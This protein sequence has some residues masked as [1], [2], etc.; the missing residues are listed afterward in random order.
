MASDHRLLR[1]LYRQR[2][3][4]PVLP[5]QPR[6][7]E[8]G[9]VPRPGEGLQRPTADLRPALRVRTRSGQRGVGLCR[10]PQ[11]TTPL[12][13][14]N[15]TIKQPPI[16][17]SI[18]KRVLNYYLFRPRD[19]TYAYKNP[20]TSRQRRRT[21]ERPTRR[22]RLNPATPRHPAVRRP[23]ASPSA[24]PTHCPPLVGFAQPR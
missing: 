12:T 18:P 19:F 22:L 13:V 24:E 20:P 16:Q 4:S 11:V 21:A 17:Y 6:G 10:P 1:Q 15:K 3:G 9:A 8:G 7:S 14:T 5:A 2:T 23:S